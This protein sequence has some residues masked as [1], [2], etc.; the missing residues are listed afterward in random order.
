MTAR[1]AIAF[2]ALVAG[3]AGPAAAVTLA[4]P[5]NAQETAERITGP[6]SYAAPVA[7]F[8]GADVP[9]VSLEGRITRRSWRIPSQGL[10]TLQV[11][12]P[13]RAQLEEMGF[14]IVFECRDEGCGGFDFRFSLEVLPSPNM[15]VNIGR[16]RFLTAL[17]GTADEP[18][19]VVTVLAS[20]TTASAYVQIIHAEAEPLMDTPGILPAPEVE[21]EEPLPEDAPE[22][23]TDIVSRL[24]SE[25]FVV[26]ADLDFPTGSTDLGAGPYASLEALA[27]GLAARPGWR[28]ALVG[29]T[30]TV[31]G[32]ATNIELSRARAA[33]VRARLIEAYGIAPERLDAEGMGYL[34]PLASNL[35]EAGRAANR[36]VEAVLLSDG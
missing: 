34:S 20:A 1:R 35:T 36:R 26:L 16:F 19:E 13:L 4:L 5:P 2:L 17:R 18:Q 23:P 12:R 22:T 10:T 15:Y 3:L 28:L 32:L 24:E 31:G 11:L 6:D 8:D 21:S 29:H 25:G 7:P 33:S 30:D 14:D 27:D 9:Q